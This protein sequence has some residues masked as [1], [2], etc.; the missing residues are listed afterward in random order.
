MYSDYFGSIRFCNNLGHIPSLLISLTSGLDG[1]CVWEMSIFSI[2]AQGL[3]LLLKKI[4]F[5]DTQSCKSNENMDIVEIVI[6]LTLLITIHNLI[7]LSVFD[8][9]PLWAIEDEL[10][11]FMLENFHYIKVCYA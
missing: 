9:C 11:S 10:S 2:S 4:K 7:T 5:S 3:N 6:A 8:Y 1:S